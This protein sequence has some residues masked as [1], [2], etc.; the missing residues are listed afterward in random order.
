[1]PLQ[2]AVLPAQDVERGAE[3]ALQ[4]LLGA[5]PVVLPPAPDA[6]AAINLKFNTSS[7]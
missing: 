2:R 5:L 3:V 7:K 1:M 4:G 6:P